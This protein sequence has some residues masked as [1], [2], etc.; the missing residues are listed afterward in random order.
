MSEKPHDCDG[1]EAS[2]S[3]G[4]V[5]F[6]TFLDWLKERKLEGLYPFL[7]KEAITDNETLIELD[8]QEITDLCNRSNIKVGIKILLWKCIEAER[9][10]LQPQSPS[11]S[12]SQSQTQAQPSINDNKNISSSD[13]H[14][15]KRRRIKT[16]N[17]YHYN[18]R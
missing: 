11:Q 7:I 9:L 13:K 3:S 5:D 15:K 4:V 12:Q 14:E 2:S 1:E 16:N 18:R 8:K 10:K 6:P 17:H